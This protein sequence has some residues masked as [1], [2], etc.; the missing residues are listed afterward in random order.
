M[1]IAVYGTLRK[2]MPNHGKIINSKYK[3][4]FDTLPIYTMYALGHYPGLKKGHTSILMEVY[5]VTPDELSQVNALEGY[6]PHSN[7]N[8]FYDR[9]L[10]RTPWGMAYTYMY[11]PSVHDYE[12]VESGD[13]KEH[14]EMN[15][16]LRQIIAQC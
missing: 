10:I 3:G 7:T 16:K 4:S 14:Y 1:L 12:E 11:I 2:N 5:D 15:I 6:N 8:T 13:W 9:I